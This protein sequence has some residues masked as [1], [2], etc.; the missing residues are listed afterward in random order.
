MLCLC[1]HYITVTAALAESPQ[2]QQS[3]N[4]RQLVKVTASTAPRPVITPIQLALPDQ[5]LCKWH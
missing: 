1:Q 3:L 4:E 2:A 5:V